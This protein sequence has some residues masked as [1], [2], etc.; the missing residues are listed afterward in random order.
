M[1]LNNKV[2]ITVVIGFSFFFLLEQFI[3]WHH[4]HKTPSEH[5][6]PFTYLVLI[7]DT[8]HNF[9]D[10]VIIGSSFI[11]SPNLGITTSLVVMLHEI[12]QELG[13]FG[14]LIHGGWKKLKALL[15]NFISAFSVVFG[16]IVA[17]FFSQKF[18][19]TILLPFAAGSFLYIACS[20]LIPEIKRHPK[21]KDSLLHF[22]FFIF[23]ILIVFI[24]KD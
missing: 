17:Y 11:V 23:G 3:H 24:L 7:S 1:G 12:P 13:D 21:L 9:I 19:L 5:V 15:F 22:L 6:H 2:F 14:V 20:D 18:N 16:G 10:G 8:V 4:C